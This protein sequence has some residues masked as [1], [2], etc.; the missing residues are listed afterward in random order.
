[1]A[2]A[3]QGMKTGDISDARDS[4]D[5]EEEIRYNSLPAFVIAAGKNLCGVAQLLPHPMLYPMRV[6][7]ENALRAHLSMC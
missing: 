1:M 5:E 7:R 2:K 4:E 3:S 6:G